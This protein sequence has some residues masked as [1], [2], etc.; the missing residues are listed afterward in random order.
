MIDPQLSADRAERRKRRQEIIN[1]EISQKMKKLNESGDTV[2]S[3]FS[4]V[5]DTC[6]TQETEESDELQDGR[7]EDEEMEIEMDVAGE[8][9]VEDTDKKA[10]LVDRD[11]QT[12]VSALAQEKVHVATQT[13]EFDY[14]F[15]SATKTQPFTEDYFKDSDDKTRF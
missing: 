2:E 10:V 3:I 1:R 14:L 13:T 15:C 5:E 4:E 8:K 7:S 12:L 11:S 9:P 6:T